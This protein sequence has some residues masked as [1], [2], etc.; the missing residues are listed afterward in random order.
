MVS[1]SKSLPED[2]AQDFRLSSWTGAFAD[3]EVEEQYRTTTVQRR[4][5]RIRIITS[6]GA[7]F[8]LGGGIVDVLLVGSVR[9]LLVLFTIRV[10]VALALVVTAVVVPGIA[11]RAETVLLPVVLLVAVATWTIIAL[12]PDALMAHAMTSVVVVVVIYVFVPLPTIHAMLGAVVL[13][14]GFIVTGCVRGSAADNELA[15]VILYM[16]LG[17]VLGALANRDLR[18][19]RRREYA[20]VEL[21]RRAYEDLERAMQAH[22]VTERALV[23]SEARYRSL[24]EVSPY[25]ITVHRNGR[26]LYVNPTGLRLLGA[27]GLQDLEG[28][29]VF[30]LIQPE[31]REIIEQRIRQLDLEEVDTLPPVELEVQSLDGTVRQCEVVSVQVPFDGEPAVQSV[32]QDV[33][34][35]RRLLDEL[36]RLAITDPL[37]GIS[38]RRQFFES[39]E[40]EWTRARRHSRHLTVAMID[41]DEF[42]QVNDRHGHAVGDQALVGFVRI[43]QRV[44]RSSDL[45][46][47]VGGEEFGLLLPETDIDGGHELA[48]RLRVA[49]ESTPVDSAAG[50][51]QLTV[52]IGVAQCQLDSEQPDDAIRRS[53]DV[54]LDAKRSGRNQIGVA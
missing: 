10:V 18:Q 11:G 14:V 46:A 44:L 15:L 7:L 33:S 21:Q 47:R 41:L 27:D 25:S 20:T 1:R 37:T 4:L 34:E 35:R 32:V 28:Q 40:R 51:L 17:N 24:V 16:I 5:E 38:N 9:E 36:R 54:L 52:S 39:L 29:S 53:D 13:S 31:F 12:S 45:M 8:Y 30:D 3:R 42:K 49:V 23:E 2:R 22:Q 43:A 19:G 6:F 26:V 50:P 48:E